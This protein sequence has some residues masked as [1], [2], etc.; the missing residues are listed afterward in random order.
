[1][2]E[3]F[4]PIIDITTGKDLIPA[5]VYG[6]E[7]NDLFPSF[8]SL[9]TCASHFDFLLTFLQEGHKRAGVWRDLLLSVDLEV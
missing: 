3:C 8:V 7:Y 6:Y 1:M 4:D 5:L 9:Q 2:Q